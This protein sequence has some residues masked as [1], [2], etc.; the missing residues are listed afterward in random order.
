[1]K[2]RLAIIQTAVHQNGRNL[3]LAAQHM[4]AIARSVTIQWNT[5]FARIA[6]KQWPIKLTA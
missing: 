2:M 6:P 5:C 4:T 3:H 1:M